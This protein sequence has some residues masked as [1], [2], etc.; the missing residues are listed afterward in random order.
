VRYTARDEDVFAIVERPAP[1]V[2]LPDVV[3]TP[4]TDVT[5]VTG[6]VL[7]WA[8]TTGGLRV[9][10][11]AAATVTDDDAPVAVR[12]RDVAATPA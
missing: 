2:T 5:T 9:E 8:S 6:D 10:L 3:A 4:T 7:R 11:A 12:C 1:V